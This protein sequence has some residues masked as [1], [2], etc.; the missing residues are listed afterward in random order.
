MAVSSAAGEGEEERNLLPGHD[1]KDGEC[2]DNIIASETEFLVQ[3][4]I[5]LYLLV[6]AD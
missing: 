6:V 5:S 2:G 4:D 3:T 1:D